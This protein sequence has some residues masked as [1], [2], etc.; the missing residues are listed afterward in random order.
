MLA[1][2]ASL[3]RLVEIVGEAAPNISAQRRQAVADIPGTRITGM[4]TRLAHAYRAV[5]REVLWRTFR[6]DLPTLFR[7]LEAEFNP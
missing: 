3:K 4:R 6:E 5:N 7:V 1:K 2:M